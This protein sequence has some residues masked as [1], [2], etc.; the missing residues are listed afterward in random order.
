MAVL[1]QIRNRG[2]FLVA[3]VGLALF[4]FIAEE[5]VRSFQSTANENRQ[6]VGEVNGK[7]LSIQDFNSMVDE[8]AEFEKARR[9]T[10]QLDEQSMAY[11]RDNAW[12]NYVTMQ[13]VEKECNEV[14]ITVTDAELQDVVTKGNSQL[15]EQF[16]Q[17]VGMNKFDATFVKQLMDQ[18]ELAKTNGQDVEQLQTV[19]NIWS[20]VEKRVREEILM[21]K[22]Y[23]LMMMSVGNNVLGKAS[24]EERANE[25]DVVLASVPFTS[26]PDAEYEVTDADKKAKYDELK[27]G[28]MNQDEFRTLEYISVKV[29][30]SEKDR[31][32]L[33]AEL[34]EVAGS[35]GGATN[36]AKAVRE[37]GSEVVYST[38]PVARKRLP[39]D[40]AACVD[41][42]SVGQVVG[43]FVS[44]DNTMNV[45]RLI[46][47]VSA[48]D[49]IEYRQIVAV[50][51]DLAASRATADSIVAAIKGGAEFD[52]IAAQKNQQGAKIW[53]TGAQYERQTVT[54]DDAKYLSVILGAQ[55]GALEVVELQNACVVLNVTDRR[56]FIDKFDVAIVKRTIN[57]SRDTYT[58]EYNKLSQFLA[59]NQTAEAIREKTSNGGEYSLQTV[60]VAAASPNVANISSTRDI[61]RWAMDED[62][63]LNDVSPLY[64]CGEND[65]LFVAILKE[66]TPRGYVSYD[67]KYVETEINNRVRNDKKAAKLVADMKGKS[68]ADVA[69]LPGAKVDTLSHVSFAQ[70]VFVP[71]IGASESRIAGAI[72]GKMPGDVVSGVVGDAGVYTVEVRATVKTGEVYE[73]NN[74]RE[75]SAQGINGAFGLNGYYFA[76]TLMSKLREK[77]NVVDHRYIFY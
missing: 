59:E 38:M 71:G 29:V 26:L 68:V 36:I 2:K 44:S 57:F 45:V 51:K 53:L 46:N 40:I 16:A 70:N 73:E 35:I 13:I 48:P 8:F 50:G 11:V 24:F 33:T 9:G 17:M 23:S 14:G 7:S 37:A 10:T 22:F 27:E 76:N 58:D 49:S 21:G 41:S 54:G 61:L 64:E 19:K 65:N 34:N 42:M 20:F 30:A 28:F 47:K 66:V 6:K 55:V 39:G 31:Q 32:E 3:A 69:K 12:Q 67:N 60:D 25:Y 1:Q 56:D 75:R 52:S 43:P 74:E 72:V 77:A 5:A 4:A 18:Y 62:R 63:K 15:L